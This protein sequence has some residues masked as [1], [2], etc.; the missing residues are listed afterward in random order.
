MFL[1]TPRSALVRVTA[2]APQSCELRETVCFSRAC[3]G[4]LK[5]GSSGARSGSSPDAQMALLVGQLGDTAEPAFL[6]CVLHLAC[7][8]QR[9]SCCEPRVTSGVV[10]CGFIVEL[11]GIARQSWAGAVWK[12]SQH[13]LVG[14]LQV[15]EVLIGQRLCQMLGKKDKYSLCLHVIDLSS[16]F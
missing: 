3:V 14:N 13:L 10:I 7:F 1:A 4:F 6:F 5:P 2:A 16:T 11:Q 9:R 8:C 15:A 12:P